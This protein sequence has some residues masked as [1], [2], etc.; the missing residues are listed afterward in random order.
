MNNSVNFRIGSVYRPPNATLDDSISLFSFM[1][2]Q[3]ENIKHYS[4]YGDFNLNDIDWVNLE[5]K[6][7]IANDFLETVTLVGATQCVNFATRNDNMLDLL[8]CSDQNMIQDI[9]CSEP[10]S[11]SDHCSISYSIQKLSKQK[12]PKTVKPCFKKADYE[13]INAY[14][15]TV[16]WNQLYAQ[17]VEPDDYYTVFREVIDNIIVNFVPFTSGTRDTKPPW[18][19]NKLK[20]LR[21]I[22]QRHWQKYKRNRNIVKYAKYE[23]SLKCYKSEVLKSKCLFEKGLFENRK[24]N[25][26]K[27]FNYI[28]KQTT[29][30]S[31]IPCLKGENFLASTDSQKAGLLSEYFGSVFT[32]DNHVLPDFHVECDSKIS[33]FHCETR[34]MVKIIKKLKLSSSPGPDGITVGFLKNIIAQIANPL[35]KLYNVSLSN[36]YIPKDWKIAHVIPIYKKGDAQL[37]S[38]Y[39]PVSLTPILCK[40][41]ERIVRIQ[42]VSYL[43]DNGIIPRSQHGFLSKKSTVSNLI[44]CLDKWTENYDRGIQTD[45]IY[46]DYSKCFD[47]VVHSKLLYKLAKYGFSDNAYKWIEN[48]LINRVQHVK[49]GTC[50]SDAQEVISGVPQGTVLG[51][52]L[53]LCFSSDIKDIVKNCHLSMYADDTKLYL[54]N[55]NIN[56]C[57]LLQEDLNSVFS[58]AKSWQLKLNPDKTK[59]LCIGNCRVNFDFKLNGTD[60]DRVESICDI[61]VNI[62]SN[63]K[64]TNH[65]NRVVKRGFFNI[66]NMFNTFKGHN[67]EFY[68]NM[69]RTYVRPILESSSQV[70]SPYL[71]GNIDKLESVQ[72]YFTRKLPGLS[73]RSYKDRLS[74]LQLESL[75]ARRI[76]A[77][78][79]LYYKVLSNKTVVNTDNCIRTFNS[80]RGHNH[81]L[82]HHYS[83][84][85]ARKNFWA[86]R[87]V[88]NWNSLSHEIVNCTSVYAFKKKLK[89]VNFLCR[90]SAS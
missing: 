8:L 88:K 9:Y 51:P 29:V 56:D 4:I 32:S 14:L 6:C 20:N 81:H 52:L 61:G 67:T 86:N 17:C 64:F 70:W 82:Y 48:F 53:F 37:P 59:H 3:L 80:H 35:C 46:L 69:Y 63:L 1:K 33:S 44:E 43:F 90:G 23:E 79:I 55:K 2:S 16:D 54:G 85:E 83:R 65:C 74:H 15:A 40:V 7:Q 75:E 57:N 21:R 71:I 13:L 68:V 58:W 28:K 87:I 60:I 47:S 19:N 76:K 38:N 34:T 41:L 22:K 18:Y 49:V 73:D 62:Q 10:F 89:H 42:I 84:T 78:I 26:K 72:R 25:S 45:V 30:C 31:E 39:R 12:K 66:R 50:L 27:F 77:D 5:A 11:G 24:Q 36:G